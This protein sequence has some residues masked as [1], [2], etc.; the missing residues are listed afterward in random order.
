MDPGLFTVDQL[1]A[2]LGA[3]L[4]AVTALLV[5]L[6]S[7]SEWTRTR[8]PAY[9]I[10]GG[11]FALDVL[12]HVAG[13]A[14][15]SFSR[16]SM[17]ALARLSVPIVLHFLE[18]CFLVL[19]TQAMAV[20]DRTRSREVRRVTTWLFEINVVIAVVVQVVWY[21]VARPDPT[22]SFGHYWGERVLTGWELLLLGLGT[23][24]SFVLR[25]D[26]R[27][28]PALM[29]MAL[30]KVAYLAN[31][32]VWDGSVLWLSLINWTAGA[33]ASVMLLAATHFG[34][35]AETFTDPLTRLHN[36]RY[37]MTRAP[38][39]WDRARRRGGYLTILVM[40]LD[41]FKRYNDTEGHVAGDH[42]LRGVARVL[43][44]HLR[45]YDLLCRWGGE[46]FIA[47]LPDTDAETG[48]VVAERLRLAVAD[49]FGGA[50][51]RSPVTVS[52]GVAAWPDT[53]GDWRDVIQGADEALY[54]A[55]Q[56]RNRVALYV[57]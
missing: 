12:L 57:P 19:L 15:P 25:T 17:G 35:I 38:L 43:N 37:F 22:S 20:H 5:A 46:E 44:R 7:Y 56:W 45:P 51:K 39:E 30:G 31:L 32:L 8:R 13:A 28:A 18:G 2:I 42:V 34:I 24:L 40:D 47:L 3:T 53:D 26:I 27:V 54:R 55:K 1:L 29:V 49:A 6:M 9:K 16:G 41:H 4:Q 33:V 36:R 11:A 48:V 50:D 52:V 23:Y 21:Y 14:L 10:L